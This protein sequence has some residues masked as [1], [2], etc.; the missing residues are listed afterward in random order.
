MVTLKQLLNEDR[1]KDAWLRHCGFI[2]LSLSEFQQ[3]QERLL[4]E[5]LEL[6]AKSYLGKK[7]LHGTF[8]AKR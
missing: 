3:V 5:Q 7:L 2:D 6:L 1:R 4:L 8:T